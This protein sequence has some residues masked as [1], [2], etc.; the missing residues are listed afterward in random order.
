LLALGLFLTALLAEQFNDRQT[1]ETQR[2]AITDQTIMLRDRLAI[3]LGGDIQ[4]VQ[5]LVA[6]IAAEPEL[7]ATRFARAAR[8]VLAGRTRLRNVAAAPDMVIRLIYPL[9]GNVTALGLDLRSRPDQSPAADQARRD[10]QAVLNGPIRLVQGGCGFAA[11]VPVHVEQPEAGERFWGLVSALIDCEQLYRDSGL[12]DAD[13]NLE[14]AIRGRDGD[15]DSEV[16]FGRAGIFDED[17]TLIELPLP[18]GSWRIAAIPRGGWPAHAPNVWFLRL[19]LLI[20]MLLVLLPVIALARTASKTRALSQRT[21]EALSLTEA[22]LE[23]TDNGILVID[24]DG[25][26]VSSNR[27]FIDMW[28]IPSALLDTGDDTQL[29][30]HVIDQLA[31]PEQFMRK[32]RELYDHPDANSRDTLTF[33]DG[34]VF[35]RFS[36]PQRVGATVVGRVWS[37]LDVTDQTRAEQN[38]RELSRQLSDELERSE[39]QR[40]QL[41][42]LLSA[43]PDAVWMKDPQGVFIS[44]NP[45]FAQMLGRDVDRVIGTS[46]D[47]Y[48]PAEVAEA[49]RADDRRAAESPNPILC[50]EWIDYVSDARRVLWATVKTAVRTEDG[51]L[52]GVLGIARDI[53]Q[54]Q[55]MLNELEEARNAALQAS[56][57]KSRFL[58]H[59]S[60]ELRTPLSAIIGFS[61]MLDMGAL[62]PL[63]AQQQTAVGHIQDSGRHLLALINEIL[64]LA[65]IESGQI[66]LHLEAV[67]LDPLIDEVMALS[68]PNAE[69]R[70]I[71]IERGGDAGFNVYADRTRLRQV[72][73]NLTSNAIKYNRPDGRV[74]IDVEPVG[75]RVRVRVSDTGVGIDE[76]LR[77]ALFQPFQRLGAE[78]TAIEGTG[79]G[80][81]ISRHLIEAMGGRIDFDSVAGQGSRF[82]FELKPVRPEPTTRRPSAE[83]PQAGLE[84]QLCGRVLYVEDNPVNLAV[85]EHLFERLPGVELL[86]AIDGETAMARLT[87]TPPDLV[88]MDINL[89]GMS[90]IEVLHWMRD[91]S[92][93]RDIP[94][95]AVSA[96]AMPETIR[97]GLEADFQAYITKPF[98]I[99][100]LLAQMRRYLGETPVN[101]WAADHDSLGSG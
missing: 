94:V 67:P 2:Q 59:M 9:E 5:G 80:L 92:R 48:F 31:D 101:A 35:A 75:E 95:I 89:P 50:E 49:F 55:A 38:V 13:M 86:T 27:R 30:S 62:D 46:D 1:A 20:V 77:D 7:D 85:M 68:H 42:C 3:H 29:L 54:K 56:D 11:R 17:P 58:A 33:R 32:V 52:L 44:C 76:A 36:H 18:H 98:K 87:E 28:R 6:L 72:L 47:D 96:N 15:P 10:R 93:L 83:T 43:I 40:H 65:R 4:L 22:T 69:D 34:R 73:L 70:R 12:L 82:W 64:D 23:A 37:F 90:G 99:D 60:H 24:L 74:G 39:Q 78:K 14:V 61:Q 41:Q 100:Q 71:R 88:L 57:A 25:R 19:A 63:T 45:E 8:A 97:A 16:F 91:R 81:I 21:A 51:R 84:R 66:E 79:I 26:V 53:T